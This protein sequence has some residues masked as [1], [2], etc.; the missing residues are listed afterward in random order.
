M[1]AARVRNQGVA[2]NPTKVSG[3]CGR[4]FCCLAYEDS[5]YTELKKGIPRNGTVLASRIPGA[6]LVT[7][8]GLGHLLFWEDPRGFARA[9]TSFL[10]PPGRPGSAAAAR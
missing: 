8:P 3:L 1:P 9:V 4:L 6:R 2:L 7:F 5:T 10:R